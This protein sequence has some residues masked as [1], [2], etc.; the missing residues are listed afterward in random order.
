[1]AHQITLK[2]IKKAAELVVGFSNKYMY[3]FRLEKDIHNG[4][5]FYHFKLTL[6]LYFDQRTKNTK[7]EFY[8]HTKKELVMKM[9]DLDDINDFEYCFMPF[10]F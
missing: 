2:E 7:Y 5:Q 9:L 8:A 6:T 10:C 3:D 4:N 1:M